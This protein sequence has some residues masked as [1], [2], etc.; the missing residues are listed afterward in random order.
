MH[1]RPTFGRAVSAGVLVAA[2]LT[3]AAARAGGQPGRQYA[4]RVSGMTWSLGR[5]ESQPAHWSISCSSPKTCTAVGTTFTGQAP[6]WM[7]ERW[8]GGGWM[9]QSRSRSPESLSGVSCAT[10]R[11]CMAVGATGENRTARAL[12]ERWSGGRWSVQRIPTPR[13]LSGADQVSCPTVNMCVAVGQTQ[14]QGMSSPLGPVGRPFI[15]M[16][17]GARWSI[18]DWRLPTGCSSPASTA[19]QSGVGELVGVSCASASVCVAV[20]LAQDRL[21]NQWPVAA[22]WNGHR[23]ATTFNRPP[24]YPQPGLPATFYSVSCASISFCVAVGGGGRYGVIE[25]WNGQKWASQRVNAPGW[26][27]LGVSCPSAHACIALSNGA[28]GSSP[29]LF[30]VDR[31]NGRSWTGVQRTTVPTAMGYQHA[32]LDAPLALACP[33]RHTCIVPVS[34]FG[35]QPYSRAL[36]LRF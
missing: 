35:P 14:T 30:E 32:N 31:W 4:S 15:A 28:V 18:S 2:L 19:C 3:V 8:N 16:W 12:V 21:G 33:S 10:N 11:M 7:I 22:T 13:D 1:R 34:W 36:Y 26:T 17:N 5:L 6:S 27:A 25:S 9:I 24:H 29:T 20:G 23:W